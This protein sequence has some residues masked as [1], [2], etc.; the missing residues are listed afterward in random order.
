M[1]AMTY[2][3]GLGFKRSYKAQIQEEEQQYAFMNPGYQFSQSSSNTSGEF[4]APPPLK[5]YYPIKRNVY[6]RS[7]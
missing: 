4:S 1:V 6:R 5:V 3:I 2:K 7:I